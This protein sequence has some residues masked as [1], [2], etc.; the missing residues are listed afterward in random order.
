MPS[1]HN[2][3]QG[4]HISKIAEKHHFFDYNIIWDDGANAAIKAKRDNPHVLNP[5]D[6]VVIPDKTE[7]KETRPTTKMHV[8][9][10]KRQKLQLWI[11]VH[12]YD[13][14][15]AANADMVFKVEGAEK[16]LKLGASGTVYKP[17]KV[18]D[19]EGHLKVEALNIDTAMKIGY[20]DPV[21]EPTGQHARLNNLGYNAGTV[22]N[23]DPEQL[24]SAVEEFQ[25]DNSLPLTG[26]CD[27]AT[28]AK[29]KEIH[30][31]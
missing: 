26:E 13:D 18:S 23:P 17:I 24:K 22:G 28:R 25:C 14:E 6:V 4:D 12:N 30:K 16:A 2:V 9:K 15:V 27:A 20:L 11:E 10:V 1:N 7:K 8:F 5:G 19:G 31:C 3:E 21:E 29:L